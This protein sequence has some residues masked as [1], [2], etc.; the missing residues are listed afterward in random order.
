MT[1]DF[2]RVR[3]HVTRWLAVLAAAPLVVIAGPAANAAAPANDELANAVV[4]Q[5]PLPQTV[6]VDTTEATAAPTDPPS[7]GC[8]TSPPGATAWFTY[9]AEATT[10]LV[11]DYSTE[12]YAGTLDIFVVDDGGAL[13]PYAGACG[14]ATFVLEVTAATTYVLLVSACCDPTAPG[15]PTTITLRP[16]PPPIEIGVTITS[17]TVVPRTGVAQIAGAVTCNL[18]VGVGI[19]AG[20]LRQRV[21]GTAAIVDGS[22]SAFVACEEGTGAWTATVTGDGAFRVGPAHVELAATACERF[23][24]D[25]FELATTVRLSPSR[26]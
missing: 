26:A 25:H 18:D 16:L 1:K 13:V 11:V 15:G 22:F 8:F 14:P 20:L 7:A 2:A 3:T 10:E 24:C 23:L 4:I 19:H 9:T 12:N 17:S 6:S 5:N 21:P